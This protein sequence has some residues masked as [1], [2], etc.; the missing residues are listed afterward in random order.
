MAD[1][2]NFNSTVPDGHVMKTSDQPKLA[3]N[4]LP[5]RTKIGMAQSYSFL[6]WNLTNGRFPLALAPGAKNPGRVGPPGPVVTG[7]AFEKDW[8]LN[9]LD[10][11]QNETYGFVTD[12]RA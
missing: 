6:A 12:A 8:F 5:H 10:N 2:P 4:S 7:P 11:Q 3:P 1:L 9:F